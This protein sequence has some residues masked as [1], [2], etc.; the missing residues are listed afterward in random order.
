[1]AWLYDNVKVNVAFKERYI[2][3][4][5]LRIG[6]TAMLPLLTTAQDFYTYI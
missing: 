3:S 4:A 5:M 1:M 6:N 2:K